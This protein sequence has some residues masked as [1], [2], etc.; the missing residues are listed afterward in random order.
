M[1]ALPLQN[2]SCPEDG[3]FLT[4]IWIAKENG[5]TFAKKGFSSL[6]IIYTVYSQR[7]VPFLA[8]APQHQVKKRYVLKSDIA[9]LSEQLVSSQPP[10]PLKM[11]LITGKT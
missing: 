5:E 1:K 9:R 7:H 6:Q 3:Y 2:L 11:K 10:L 8:H 4:Q